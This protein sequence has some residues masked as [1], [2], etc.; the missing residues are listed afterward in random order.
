MRWLRPSWT[1]NCSCTTDDEQAGQKCEEEQ[2]ATVSGKAVAALY[3]VRLCAEQ[4]CVTECGD[5]NIC[6][7]PNFQDNKDT[8]TGT[9]TTATVSGKIS[10]KCSACA[11]QKCP[12]QTAQCDATKGCM[13]M[14]DGGCACECRYPDNDNETQS[15]ED[16]LA[17]NTSAQAK[18][19]V[20]AVLNCVSEACP[21][22]CDDATVCVCK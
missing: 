8:Y 6:T 5:E 21:A 12:A 4:K 15:C 22:E 20:N 11:E 17:S 13:E 14:I 9:D 16:T 1:S 7:C 3:Q 2:T 10:D 19:V 18:T